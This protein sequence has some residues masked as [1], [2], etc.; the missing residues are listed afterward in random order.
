MAFAY[1]LGILGRTPL[2]IWLFFAFVLLRGLGAT[3]PRVGSLRGVFVVP[4]LFMAWG[5]LC[6]AMRLFAGEPALAAW[7]CAVAV[8]ALLGIL[9]GPRSLA[10]DRRQGLVGRP[11]SWLPLARYVAIFGAHY[12]L[13][14]AAVLSPER[15]ESLELW[16]IAV[17]G[18]SFGY[19]AGWTAR[20]VRSYRQAPDATLC[21][22]GTART[23]RARALG[24]GAA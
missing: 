8:A 7:S 1:V 4:G 6:L 15:R 20:F 5:A 3:R 10:V 22:P 16:E 17:S 2:W 21:R 18:V 14:V 19:F 13:G 23:G 24:N 9:S 11:G 12:A